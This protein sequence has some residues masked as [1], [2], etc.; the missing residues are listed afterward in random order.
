MKGFLKKI[1]L[2]ISMILLVLGLSTISVNAWGNC[3]GSPCGCKTHTSCDAAKNE[4]CAQGIDCWFG[5]V[6]SA[7]P[8]HDWDTAN[9][10]YVDSWQSAYQAA[11]CTSNGYKI[12]TTKYLVDCKKCNA[13]EITTH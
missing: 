9:K 6:G 13:R 4:S 12:I 3:G 1:P 8:G 11:S 10:K 2:G 5:D 7:C